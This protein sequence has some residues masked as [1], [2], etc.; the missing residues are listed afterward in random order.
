[1]NVKTV[2]GNCGEVAVASV[3]EKA[4][5]PSPQGHSMGTDM[6]PD[7]SGFIAKRKKAKKRRLNTLGA[8]PANHIP[9]VVD[10][11]GASQKSDEGDENLDFVICG[12]ERKVL[13]D[14]SQP[15]ADCPGGCF[16]KSAEA[17]TLIEVEGYA[18]EKY[19]ATVIDSGYNVPAD[20]FIVKLE[21]KDGKFI[22]ALFDGQ[23]A[24]DN[25]WILVHE[26]L[27]AE[28]TAETTISKDEAGQLALKSLM[29]SEETITAE[30]GQIVGVVEDNFEG[31]DVLTVEVDGADG[32]SYDVYV[33]LDGEVLAFDVF[34]EVGM[35]SDEDEVET[36]E[37]EETEEAPETEVEE[38]SDPAD[39]EFLAALAEFQL[40]EVEDFLEE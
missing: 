21:R 11:Q 28:K 35:K 5:T 25:G 34:E 7:M 32:W 36:P 13:P 9:D 14:S 4:M 16:A 2:C 27:V 19:D 38:K 10:A 8:V 40:L 18:E 24:E 37:S 15:C 3:E 22:E 39:A 12:V 6:E 17:P 23:T 33:S 29:E 26:E 30:N 31:T 1:M 20:L